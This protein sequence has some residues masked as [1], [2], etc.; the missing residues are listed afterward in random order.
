MKQLQPI[1]EKQSYYK[2]IERHIAQYFD[3]LIYDKI[4]GL[5]N[6]SIGQYY[7]SNDAVKDALL[8]GKIQYVDGKFTGKFNAK[9]TKQLKDMG[10]VWEAKTSSFLLPELPLDLLGIVGQASLMF[11]E[12]HKN[13]LA[14]IYDLQPE[15]LLK[16][17]SFD[18]TYIKTLT[19]IDSRVYQTLKDDI[20]IIPELSPL[21]REVIAEEYSNNLKLYIK[22]FTDK[23]T[24]K[25]RKLVEDNMFNKGARAERLVDIIQDRFGVSQRKARFLAKQETSLL[26]SDFRNQ[27]YCECGVTTWKWSS[28]HDSRVRTLH[29]ELDGK[30]FK[31]GEMP[32]IDEKGN[33]GLPGQAFGCRCVQVPLV[34]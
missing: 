29:K 31:M 17:F 8:K 14:I 34:D 27:R 1:R 16:T 18:T 23:E 2:D 22:D 4:F 28:S 9:I 6:N 7:N 3:E 19:D 20:S 33:K 10:A 5:L 13:I 21:M 25:L 30:I 32:V 26:T 12:L 24:L 15:A 11:M